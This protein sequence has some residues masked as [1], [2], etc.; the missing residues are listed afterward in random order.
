MSSLLSPL[1]QAFAAGEKAASVDAAMIVKLTD[2]AGDFAV[3]LIIAVVILIA[4]VI[5][6]RWVS[7][8]TRRTLAR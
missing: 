8:V 3:N 7:G 1:N 6:A 2:I 5:S 4:T